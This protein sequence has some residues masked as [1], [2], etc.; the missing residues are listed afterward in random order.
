MIQYVTFHKHAQMYAIQDTHISHIGAMGEGV[1]FK[2]FLSTA[3]YSVGDPLATHVRGLGLGP[4]Y[5][6]FYVLSSALGH[7][8]ANFTP[9]TVFFRVK[10]GVFGL[11]MLFSH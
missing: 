2:Y 9:K 5:S 10:K 8:V 6:L 11:K 4:K 7:G 1:A 3:D